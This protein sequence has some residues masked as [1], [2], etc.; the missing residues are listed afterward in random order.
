MLLFTHP[1]AIPKYVLG[2]TVCGEG[3]V[4]HPGLP[5][6][7]NNYDILLCISGAPSFLLSLAPATSAFRWLDEIGL[8]SRVLLTR[9]FLPG[10][11]LGLA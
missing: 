3:E 5:Y 1:D 8:S 2:D 4:T 7:N 9:L 10:L 11:L 6:L